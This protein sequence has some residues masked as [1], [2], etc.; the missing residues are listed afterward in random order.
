MLRAGDIGLGPDDLLHGLLGLDPRA[1]AAV[2]AGVVVHVHFEAEPLRLGVDVPEQLAPALAHEIHRAHRRALV[3]LHDEHAAD[4]DAFHRFEVGRD[5]VAGDVAVQPEPVDPGTGVRR[6]PAKTLLQGVSACPGRRKSHEQRQNSQSN[7]NRL[8]SD[9]PFNVTAPHRIRSHHDRVHPRR[10]PRP[11]SIA[12][13]NREVPP[14]LARKNGDIR[15]ILASCLGLQGRHVSIPRPIV[16]SSRQTGKGKA[17]TGSR[18][19]R[20]KSE[21]EYAQL[22]GRARLRSAAGKKVT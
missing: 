9:C 13:R 12:D 14:W 21:Q 18:R 5:A 4:A 20:P 2:P 19:V 11:Q 22:I 7:S 6:R 8:H 16:A 17:A 1:A 15:H 3:H 10:Y